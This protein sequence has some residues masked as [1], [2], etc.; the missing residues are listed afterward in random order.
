MR[1]GKGMT[2]NPCEIAQMMHRNGVTAADVRKV[3]EWSGQEP[4][5]R[6]K[7]IIARLEFIEISEGRK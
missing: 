6:M 5:E 4:P 7:K 2:D 3:W 1:G